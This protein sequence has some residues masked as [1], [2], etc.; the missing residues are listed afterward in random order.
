M[1]QKRP[2]LDPDPI[3]MFLMFS[4]INIF[5]VILNKSK[6]LITL[7][8]KVKTIIWTKLY[9]KQFY[10]LKEF[11]L[12]VFLWIKDLDPDPAFSRIRIRVTQKDWIWPDLTGS[13]SESATPLKRILNNKTLIS[14]FWYVDSFML[15]FLLTVN[16][17]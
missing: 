4:N 6:H 10:I 1:T 2:E 12:Q 17:K 14:F 8:F 16:K 9:F 3:D 15:L 5:Y 11:E 13:R 7:K